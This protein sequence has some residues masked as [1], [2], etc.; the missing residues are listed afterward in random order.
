MPS[1]RHSE[2]MTDLLGRLRGPEPS[3]LLPP[4][5]V[6]ERC[7]HSRLPGAGCHACVD[8]CPVRA[9]IIDD[10]RLGIAVDRCDGCD[11]CAPACPEGAIVERFSVA[12]HH[13]DGVETAFAA[14]PAAGVDGGAEGLMPCLHLLGDRAL[15]RLHARGVRRLLLCAGDCDAC[16]RGGVARVQD[17]AARVSALLAARA[18][19][20]LMLEALPRADWTSALVAARVASRSRA[21][22]RRALLWDWVGS[23]ADGVAELAEREQDGLPRFVPPGRLVGKSE[24]DGARRRAGP[25]ASNT[26]ARDP[27]G[28]FSL[29][30]PA[31][32]GQ[33]CTG[34]DACARICPHQVLRVEPDAYRIDPDGCT[35]CGLCVDVCAVAAMR[36]YSPAPAPET[37]VPLYAAR[38]SACG[39][40]FHMPKAGAARC[41]VCKQA[42]H[43]QRLF[44]VLQS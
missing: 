24:S 28:R 2:S 5:V 20:G 37:R 39:V 34:C 27:V 21:V 23:A 25:D 4:E 6:A 13:C 29:H 30:A 10:E 22:G 32:D 43:H 16:P 33:R 15:L 36:V 9:W 38:C 35:G 42:A 26:P 12:R 44:Q 3:D 17:Y 11:L 14:C 31:I 40:R 18:R 41:P 7:V 19:P 8:A 1:A